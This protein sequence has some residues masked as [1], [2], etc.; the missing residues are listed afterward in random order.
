MTGTVHRRESGVTDQ[1]FSADEIDTS[2]PHPAR[3]YDFYLGGRDN[4]QV[5]REAAAGVVR[6]IPEILTAARMNRAFLERAVRSVVESGVR[7]IIDVGTGIPT[8]PNPHEIARG[9][10]PDVK[11]AYVDN[12]PIVASHAGAR[13]TGTPD[14]GFALADIRKPETI[15]EHPAV[16]ELIDFD[17]PVALLLV[18]VL[19]F[20]R[21]DEGPAGIVATLAEALP[22]GSRLVL[23]HATSD[24]HPDG[25]PEVLKIYKNATATLNP[26]PHADV[27]PL[28]DGFRLLEPGLV[29]VPLWRPDGPPPPAGELGRIGFYGGVGVK[30]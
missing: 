13:L 28:F 21:D 25:M 2:R 10:A 24:F 30:E 6:Q 5:D 18:A 14:T 19:H 15:L 16:R 20:V 27:L 29:Q 23:S 3:M 7:Q 8:S 17:R 26:R 1:G 9:V 12:D 11:V 22:P 4:Y